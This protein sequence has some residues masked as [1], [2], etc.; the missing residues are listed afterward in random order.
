MLMLLYQS[1]VKNYH[2]EQTITD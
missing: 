2:Y 1:E